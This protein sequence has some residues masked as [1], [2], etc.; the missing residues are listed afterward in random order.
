M[1]GELMQEENFQIVT[2]QENYVENVLSNLSTNSDT[3]MLTNNSVYEDTNSEKKKQFNDYFLDF[4][5]SNSIQYSTIDQKVVT[6]TSCTQTINTT[7]DESSRIDFH[8]QPSTSKQ[9]FN[10]SNIQPTI[11]TKSDYEIHYYDIDYLSYDNQQPP[12]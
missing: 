4:L 2:I 1:T 5:Q 10:Y 8:N 12:N 7:Q 3:E 6:E 9:L 11:P